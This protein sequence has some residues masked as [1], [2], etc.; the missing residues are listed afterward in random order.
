MLFQPIFEHAINNFDDVM[1]HHANCQLFIEHIKRNT[2]LIKVIS[3]N[4]GDYTDATLDLDE[5][6]VNLNGT[7]NSHDGKIRVVEG[8]L[9]Y[10]PSK[11]VYLYNDS[12]GEY[13]SLYVLRSLRF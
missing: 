4:T 8:K 12:D 5:M 13:F 1:G 2:G 9:D 10:E 6:P 11:F 7:F 3:D